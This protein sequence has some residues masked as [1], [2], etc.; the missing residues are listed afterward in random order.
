[1]AAQEIRGNAVHLTVPAGAAPSDP[2]Q[3]AYG[4]L[5][6]L[7]TGPCELRFEGTLANRQVHAELRRNIMALHERIVADGCPTITVDVR[8]LHFVDSSAIRIFVDWIG[9]AIGAHYQIVFLTDPTMTWQRLSFDA[10]KSLGTDAVQVREMGPSPA[11]KGD[12]AE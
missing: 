4:P 3:S 10:L 5:R 1:L 12:P 2:P 8:G 6:F 9:Y 11:T 7:V